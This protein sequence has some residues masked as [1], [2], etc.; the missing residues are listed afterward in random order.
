MR[1][2]TPGLSELCHRSFAGDSLTEIFL[3]KRD[4]HGRIFMHH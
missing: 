2:L 3:T 1:I 4:D